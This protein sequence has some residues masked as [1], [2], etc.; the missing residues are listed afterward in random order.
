V[1][2]SSRLS[3][4]V[5]G[6][7]GLSVGITSALLMIL[8]FLMTRKSQMSYVLY[9]HFFNHLIVFGA[10]VVSMY[11]ERK[12]NPDLRF[13][14]AYYTG[15]KT[16]ITGSLIFNFFLLIY[17]SFINSTYFLNMRDTTALGE[18]MTPVVVS[19]V[20]FTEQVA[21]ALIYSLIGSFLFKFRSVT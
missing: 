10:V 18:Y 5:S 6:H 21:A 19:I 9:L 20:F 8:F 15:V 11:V 13:L 17:F 12:N 16:A 1:I 3:K 2:I 7:A 14:G 4:L